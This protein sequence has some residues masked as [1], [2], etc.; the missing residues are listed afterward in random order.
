V[1]FL[2]L[3]VAY[4]TKTEW[5]LYGPDLNGVYGG[6]NGVGGFDA[7][8]PKL[9]LFNPTIS[10]CRGNILGFYSSVQGAVVWNASRPTGYGAV[11]GYGQCRWRMARAFAFIRMARALG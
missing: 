1:E 10:D 7:V 11:P 8:S 6:L 3:G 2:E 4:G 9:N 5:K